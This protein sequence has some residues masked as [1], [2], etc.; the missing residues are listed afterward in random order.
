MKAETARFKF[1]VIRRAGLSLVEALIA[2][3]ITAM[4]LT[5][6]A[7]AFHASTAA[8]EMNDEFYRAQQAA[9]V[10]LNQIMD[11]VRK[12][13]SGV[14]DTSNLELTTDAG[15]D[16]VYSVSGTDLMMTF[17]PP[18]ALSPTSVRL[19]SNIKTLT[20][21]TDGK[22]IS[23]LV[24]VTVGS[25]TVTLCGSAFPRRLMTYQ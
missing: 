2:L 3:A 6:V 17:T 16:R 11:Q 7:A 8:I 25:N 14:V 20:F 10:S 1:R 13:Q 19:A 22:S 15:L 18:G 12:C 4:L 9:R 5:S 24:T 23:M 21:S